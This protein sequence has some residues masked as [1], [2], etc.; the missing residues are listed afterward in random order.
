MSDELI[1]G[2]LINKSTYVI[3]RLKSNFYVWN[4]DSQQLEAIGT[5]NKTRVGQ[6]DIP[7]TDKGGGIYSVD[8]P[9]ECTTAGKYVALYCEKIGD[10]PDITD[11]VFKQEEFVWTGSAKITIQDLLSTALGA[12]SK[13]LI[14]TDAQDLSASLDV[15]AKKIN[16]ST[17]MNAD[18]VLQKM[19]D[20]LDTAVGGSPTA[21]SI[22]QM[23]QFARNISEADVKVDT[24][25]TPW[26]L[27][28]YKKG[29]S[30][31]LA[32]KNLKDVAGNNLTS[33]TTVIGQIVEP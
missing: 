2:Y 26:Q 8:F 9:A 15:N 31:E 5:W 1:A 29:T 25:P 12:D 17:P 10:D 16:A 21:N 7:Q 22:N 19:L 27:V 3:L 20:G 33:I 11:R 30:T 24:E 23:L 4:E 6:C 28:F 13:I 32:R 18:D 14:S